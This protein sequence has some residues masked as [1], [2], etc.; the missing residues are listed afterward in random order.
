M[1]AKR[2]NLT[3]RIGQA[4]LLSYCAYEFNIYDR[5][6]GYQNYPT[7]KNTALFGSGIEIVKTIQRLK[8][9]LVAVYL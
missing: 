5:R 6:V 1:F 3:Q 9:K 8:C 7:V 4:F 2:A